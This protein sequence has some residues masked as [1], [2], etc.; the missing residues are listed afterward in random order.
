MSTFDDYVFLAPIAIEPAIPIDSA[1]SPVCDIGRQV[2][3]SASAR[4]LA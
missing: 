2:I 4:C 3:P 1:G